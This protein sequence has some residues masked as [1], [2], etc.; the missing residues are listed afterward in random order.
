MSK[1]EITLQ[2]IFLALKRYLVWIC[3]TTFL[4]TVGA[5]AYAK[6]FITPMYST[7]VS[8]CVF[9]DQRTCDEVTS[10]Q[11]AADARIAYTYEILLT[12]QPVL[13]A[14]STSMDGAVSVK[15]LAGMISA[16]NVSSTQIINVTVQNS[17]PQLAAVIANT[18]AE[19]APDTLNSIARGGEM[20]AVDRAEV[21]TAPYSPDIGKYV[22]TGFILGL[23]LSCAVVIL[24]ALL[25]TTI[26]RE[27]DLERSF[28]LPVLGTVPSMT[29]PAK[30]GSKRKER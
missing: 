7:T 18:L 10:T 25:D 20:V 4:F 28:K 2:D 17:D 1:V 22:S 27:E 8:L 13:E 12:S 21:P 23:L 19:V 14:V 15:E 6:F 11:M 30:A 3:L 29:G 16:S 5:W 9:A 26:W 24:I